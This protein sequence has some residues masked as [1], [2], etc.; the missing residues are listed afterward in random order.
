M[1]FSKAKQTCQA[2]VVLQ[3]PASA[4]VLPAKE[5]NCCKAHYHLVDF[6]PAGTQLTISITCSTFFVCITFS[7][8]FK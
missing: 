3:T 5:T 6:P 7:T 4:D 8:F 1:E 2:V